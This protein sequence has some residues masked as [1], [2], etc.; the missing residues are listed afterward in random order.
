MQRL[1]ARLLLLIALAGNFVPL[2]LAATAAPLHSCCIRKAHRCHDSALTDSTQIAA[3]TTGCCNHDC[4]RA[5]TAPQWATPQS[6]AVA[7]FA[8]PIENTLPELPADAPL[9]TFSAT[10]SSRAPPNIA[11]G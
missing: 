11:I 1:T 7:A 2:A 6:P 10:H 4:C 3:R 5:V 8:R 9:T